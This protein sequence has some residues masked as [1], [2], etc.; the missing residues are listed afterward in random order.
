MTFIF[1]RKGGLVSGVREKGK[2][3]VGG[4][5]CT[6]LCLYILIFGQYLGNHTWMM[7]QCHF[8]SLNVTPLVCVNHQWI[9]EW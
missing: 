5:K 2:R 6:F 9:M 7:D 3:E 4:E 8:G 1:T